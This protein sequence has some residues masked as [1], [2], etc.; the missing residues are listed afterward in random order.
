MN[1]V[2]I[3]GLLVPVPISCFSSPRG[4]GPPGHF[5]L[6]AAPSVPSAITGDS[7]DNYVPIRRNQP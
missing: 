2:D 5:R 6:G 4:H 7:R 1:T 3:V